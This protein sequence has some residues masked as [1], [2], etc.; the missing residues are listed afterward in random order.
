MVRDREE[1]KDEMIKEKTR[2]AGFGL[3]IFSICDNKV[4]G[5]K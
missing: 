3:Q 5:I 4:V 2:K 1:K